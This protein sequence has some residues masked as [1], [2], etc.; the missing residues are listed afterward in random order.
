MVKVANR[1]LTLGQVL[2]EQQCT[3]TGTGI[4][5]AEGPVPPA[6]LSSPCEAL[7]F[8]LVLLP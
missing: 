4:L 1:A 2:Y 6:P 5:M 7:S 8:V 3:D